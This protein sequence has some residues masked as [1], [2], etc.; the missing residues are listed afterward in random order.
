MAKIYIASIVQFPPTLFSVCIFPQIIP[1]ASC[2]FQDDAAVLM[3]TTTSAEAAET[4]SFTPQ[5]VIV[6]HQNLTLFFSI[7]LFDPFPIL[8][9]L[10]P[11]FCP[12]KCLHY[13]LKLQSF[14][15]W[16]VLL[17]SVPSL[18]LLSSGLK[19]KAVFLRVNVKIAI[20]IGTIS[21][22]YQVLLYYTFVDTPVCSATLIDALMT[23]WTNRIT[24]TQWPQK[25]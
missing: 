10:I 7:P 22:V 18:Y 4:Y 9:F 20:N 15:L 1:E 5:N 19:G 2:W 11:S 12:S 14:I 21:T 24:A 16:L 8:L 17:L 3:N 23:N 13:C 25:A 6:I